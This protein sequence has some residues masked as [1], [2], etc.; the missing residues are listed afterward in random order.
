MYTGNIHF[1]NLTVLSV[2]ISF[3]LPMCRNIKTKNQ[4]NVVVLILRFVNI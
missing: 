2:E 4:M 1:F 3:E